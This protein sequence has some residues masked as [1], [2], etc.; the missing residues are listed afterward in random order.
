[1]GEAQ[2]REATAAR[3]HERAPM[4]VTTRHGPV[5][6]ALLDDGPPA[7]A[8]HGAMGGYDQ[9]L[10]LVRTIGEAGYRFIA[11]SRP[12]YLGTRLSSGRRPEEQADLAA[13]LLDVLHIP[14]AAVM[15]VSGSGPCALQF[16]LQHRERCW[17]LILSSTCSG[18][19]ATRIPLAFHLLTV[20]ESL[21]SRRNFRAIP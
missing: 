20:S 21:D 2:P 15:A 17:G 13:A 7:L 6:Y 4:T 5:E 3:A 19:V 14:S 12:G 8:L 10:I 1:M 18:K 9:G 11:V 16:A